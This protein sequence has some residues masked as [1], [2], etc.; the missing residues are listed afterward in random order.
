MF[1]KDVVWN[2]LVGISL[3]FIEAAGRNQ[4]APSSNADLKAGLVPTVKARAV[5]FVA[6][7][8]I[9]GPAWN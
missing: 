1:C 4:A 6:A 8:G 7:L 2:I 5:H 3:P 9:F